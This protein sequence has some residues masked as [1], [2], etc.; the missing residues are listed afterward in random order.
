MVLSQ[1]LQFCRFCFETNFCASRLE[2]CLRSLILWICSS[3]TTS[4]MRPEIS[5]RTPKIWRMFHEIW[6][7][8]V[9]TNSCFNQILYQVFQRIRASICDFKVL[10][11]SLFLPYWSYCAHTLKSQI[12]PGEPM[13]K[14]PE[15]GRKSKVAKSMFHQISWNIRQNLTFDIVLNYFFATFF[16]AQQG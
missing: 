9:F 15:I 2:S 6:S 4:K 10:L 14:W 5:T 11:L 3:K 7:N 12:P 13:K 8:C 1:F 16:V